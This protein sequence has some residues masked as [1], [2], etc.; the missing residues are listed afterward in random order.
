MPFLG[1]FHSGIYLCSGQLALPVASEKCCL[2]G[3]LGTQQR[4]HMGCAAGGSPW[5]SWK[6]P[7]P[8]VNSPDQ[9]NHPL[10]GRDAWKALQ[11]T[12]GAP[13]RG[14]SRLTS[15]TLCHCFRPH[16]PACSISCSL[17]LSPQVTLRVEPWCWMCSWLQLAPRKVTL[18]SML[19]HHSPRPAPGVCMLSHFTHVQLC[20]PMDCSPPRSSVHG[21]LQAGILGWV[22]MSSSRGPSW[23]RDRTCVTC[24][25]C[26]AGRFFTT[27][28]TREAQ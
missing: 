19:F 9:L 10:W 13:G 26:I 24:G 7:W 18:N 17:A 12:T 5:G 28:A 1:S 21:I 20:D 8:S 11:E 14:C 22:A 16:P 2:R 25:S 15:E 6:C 23:P 4:W 27:W 3:N